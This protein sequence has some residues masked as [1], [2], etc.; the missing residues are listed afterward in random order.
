MEN[1]SHEPIESMSPLHNGLQLLKDCPMCK[2]NF[3]QTDIQVLDTYNNV[4]LLHVT[5]S[6]CTHAMLSLFA[7]SQLGV[8][9]VGMATDLSA[10]DAERV[11][12]STPIHE[13]EIL[14]F[15][16]FLGGTHKNK[17]RIEDLFV[18]KEMNV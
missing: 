8:S 3:T 2:T 10:A 12:G 15:H 18:T 14:S 1:H 13:D 17:K 9:S 7:I 16:A 4:H 6:T 5:C 11:L